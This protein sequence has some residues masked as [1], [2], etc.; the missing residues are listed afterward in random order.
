[1]SDSHDYRIAGIGRRAK[2]LIAGGCDADEAEE[3]MRVE[4]ERLAEQR[5]WD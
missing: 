1:M 4:N 2:G 3:F 5:M